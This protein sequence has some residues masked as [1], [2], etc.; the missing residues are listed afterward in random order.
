MTPRR[1]TVTV[2]STSGEQRRASAATSFR[3]APPPSGRHGGG[4]SLGCQTVSL[5]QKTKSYGIPVRFRLRSSGP[6]LP[7]AA[8]LGVFSRHLRRDWGT[9]RRL[10]TSIEQ[11]LQALAILNVD[12]EQARH[13][14]GQLERTT[15]RVDRRRAVRRPA[16]CL[17]GQSAL[18]RW[19]GSL[20]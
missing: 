5:V 12:I 9:M 20:P 6:I 17:A 1:A 19:A 15:W 16:G 13:T 3:T 10:S 4:R 18:D 14:L 11:H 2:C 7:T 8:G